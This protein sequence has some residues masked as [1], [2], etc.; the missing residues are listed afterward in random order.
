MLIANPTQILI[1]LGYNK[2]IDTRYLMSRY[3]D[4]VCLDYLFMP[5]GNLDYDWLQVILDCIFES[6]AYKYDKLKQ[7]IDYKYEYENNYNRTRTQTITD[8]MGERVTTADMGASKITNNDGER[9]NTTTHSEMSY[10]VDPNGNFVKNSQDVTEQNAITNTSTTDARQDK[11]T[12]STYTDTHTTEE[13]EYGDLSVRTVA[14]TLESE[15]KIAFFS[16]WDEIFKDIM[17]E[18]SELWYL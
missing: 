8:T 13:K 14:E 2:N 9:V 18:I 5:D 17:N 3:R 1:D 4:L 7:T 12:L 16:V 15:R 11:S 6:F 10:D